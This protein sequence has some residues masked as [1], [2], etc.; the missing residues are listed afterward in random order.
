MVDRPFGLAGDQ[1]GASGGDQTFETVDVEIVVAE[2]EAVTAPGRLDRRG[3]EHL[4]EVDDAR[5]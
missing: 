1:V 3:A 5:L 2:P 4:A